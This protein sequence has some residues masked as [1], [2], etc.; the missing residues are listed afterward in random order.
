V[1]AAPAQVNGAVVEARGLVKRFGGFTAVNDVDVSVPAGHI[2]AMIGPNGAGKSTVINLLGGALVP[3]RGSI[4]IR[5]SSTSGHGPHHLARLGLV[6]TFQTPKLFEGL[7]TLESMML[8]R[9]LFAKSGFFA[10]VTRAPRMRRDEADALSSA[11]GWLAFVGLDHAAERPMNALPVGSQRLVE[12]ARA[13]ATEPDVVLLD[14]PAAGLDHTETAQLARLIQ[15]IAKSGIGILLV[16]HDMHLVMSVAETVLV[17]DAGNRIALGTP[18]Q[19]REDPA[20][21][22]AYLGVVSDDGPGA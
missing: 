15:E 16:E 8:S 19:V 17:L 14:E 2:T 1:S 6:R 4:T 18:A 21:I 9:A 11:M 5:G 12:V 10:S 3:T 22:E 20:V 13:L 7:T